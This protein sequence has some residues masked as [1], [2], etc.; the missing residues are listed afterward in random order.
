MIV[1]RRDTC[2]ASDDDTDVHFDDAVFCQLFFNLN[3]WYS[4]WMNYNSE[5][6]TGLDQRGLSI[7]SLNPKDIGIMVLNSELNHT[8]QTCC[9]SPDNIVSWHTRMA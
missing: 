3:M 8:S 6:G 4:R 5:K 7:N 9:T 2:P 1:E